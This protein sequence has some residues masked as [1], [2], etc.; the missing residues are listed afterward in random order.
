M[1]LASCYQNAQVFQLG[2]SFKFSIKILSSITCKE[3][4]LT[5]PKD[6]ELEYNF[7]NKASLYFLVKPFLSQHSNVPTKIFLLFKKLT[8]KVNHRRQISDIFLF[9]PYIIED[10]V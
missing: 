1:H 4:T 7:I 8:K 2:M 10:I 6:N 3:Q 5:F 9:S